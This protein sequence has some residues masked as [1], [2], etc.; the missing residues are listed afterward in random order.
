MV[1]GNVGLVIISTHH[2]STTPFCYCFPYADSLYNSWN[3]W[4][5]QKDISVG[6]AVLFDD[7]PIFYSVDD[8]VNIVS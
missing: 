5:G 8:V 1:D 6:R 7:H 2:A 3:L 4:V